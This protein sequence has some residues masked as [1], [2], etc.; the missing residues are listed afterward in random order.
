MTVI[1][2]SAPS[3]LKQEKVNLTNASHASADILAQQSAKRFD[4]Q[5]NLLIVSD[6][7]EDI[8]L[9]KPN[10]S[11]NPE[12]GKVIAGQMRTRFL[13]LG[14]NI[15]ESTLTQGSKNTAT[16]TGTYNFRGN[17]MNVYVRMTNQRTGEVIGLHE[18]SLPLSYDIKKYMNR[19]KDSLPL[20]PHLI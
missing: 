17:R 18:Y 7:Q 2:A 10:I 12:I 11:S 9:N 5:S 1:G 4:R 19:D 8:D 16:V 13:A 3:I 20:I 15:F 6:L 14:Y